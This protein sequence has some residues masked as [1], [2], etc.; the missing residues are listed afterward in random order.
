[1]HFRFNWVALICLVFFA[2]TGLGFRAANSASASE[3][4]AAQPISEAENPDEM[5]D[6]KVWREGKAPELLS[7]DILYILPGAEGNLYLDV[8]EL[9]IIGDGKTCLPVKI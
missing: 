4:E 5:K 6:K 1:M 8:E 9:T 3:K 2:W 7:G